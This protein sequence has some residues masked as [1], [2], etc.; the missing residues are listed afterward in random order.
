MQH[1][2]VRE[3]LARMVAFH[4]EGWVD[5][6]IPALGGKTPRQAVKTTE[7]RESVEALL[8]SAERR[9]RRD[10]SL[11]QETLTAIDGVRQRLNLPGR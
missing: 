3:H 1:Q 11:G 9:A 8:R 10:E 5:E 7:G 2:E 6:K 4:W